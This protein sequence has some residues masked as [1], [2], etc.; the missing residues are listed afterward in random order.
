YQVAIKYWCGKPYI[1]KNQ[2][3]RNIRQLKL[4]INQCNEREIFYS[5]DENDISYNPFSSTTPST[6]RFPPTR[7]PIPLVPNLSGGYV[8]TFRNQ[9]YLSTDSVGSL[10]FTTNVITSVISVEALLSDG[11]EILSMTRINFEENT[12]EVPF[13][14]TKIV[15]KLAAYN[16]KVSFYIGDDNKLVHST[17]AKLYFLPVGPKTVT[18]DRLYG[19]ILT[20]ANETIFPVGPYVDVGGWLAKGN[21]QANLL[22]LKNLNYNIINPDP[23]Y[24]N[25]SFIHQM[26]Q[27][28]DTIGGIYIQYSF[29]HDYK[30]I[31]KVVDQV[32]QF[33]NYSSLLTWYIA[34]EPDGEQWTNASAVFEAYNVIKKLDP[35]HPVAL[36]LNCQHSVAFYADA[37]DILGT[38]VYPV[39]VDMS[40]CTEY[41]GVCGCDNCIG[42]VILDIPK[43]TQQYMTDLNLIGHESIMKWMVS[44]AFYDQ[45][46]WWR[47]PPTSQEIRVMWYISIIYGYKG[48]MFWRFPFALNHSVKEQI[49][50]LSEE[51]KM[52]SNYILFM[53]QLPHSH[54]IISPAQSVYSGGWISKDQK[55]FLLIV[56]NGN[57]NQSAKFRLIIKDLVSSGLLYGISKIDHEKK[58]R[59]FIEDGV[60]EGSL[61][62]YGVEIFI[63]KKE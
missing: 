24:P 56:T 31:Q 16:V 7:E 33:K 62:I 38:D 10:V 49:T 3:F 8:A 27:A 47:R 46:S 37:A 60:F 2:F 42:D 39:G 32:S 63:F 43:R 58:E 34:D 20:T 45:N 1:P 28:A 25:I 41:S 12:V 53:S 9:P 52:L 48:L 11:T 22:T 61:K 44:Q 23:P 13:S 54:I 35:Y 4:D 15:P 21:I 19:G 5:T 55:T 29:R 40:Q 18:I 36:V 57:E 50:N 14:L 17:Y 26:F 51:I 30:D 6:I 59:V